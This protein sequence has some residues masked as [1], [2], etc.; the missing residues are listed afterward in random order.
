VEFRHGLRVAFFPLVLTAFALSFGPA[1]IQA[2]NFLG[3]LGAI[4]R[5]GAI[6]QLIV[7]REIAP[8]VTGIVIAGVVGTAVCADLGAREVR[9]ELDALRVQGIDVVR[10]LVFPR[11][12]AITSLAVLC[13]IF[14]LVA[15][16]FGA[17][18]VVLQNHAS[19]GPFFATFFSNSTTLEFG[20]ALVKSTI[21]GLMIGTVACYRGI[22]A[23]GGAEGVGRAVNHTVVTAF[24][25]I[26]A[27]DYVFTQYLLA[28]NPILSAPR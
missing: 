24:L 23:S 12:L 8:L 14:A 20:A 1:G 21:F 26:G 27:I 18:L 25:L 19:L 6:Y 3:L 2:S 11:L 9:E 5:L 16:M 22:H 4:D 7:V 15:G 13:N 10:S 28:T 17:V